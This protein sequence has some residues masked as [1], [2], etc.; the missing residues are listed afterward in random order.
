MGLMEVV[1]N[2]PRMRLSAPLLVQH[3]TAGDFSCRRPVQQAFACTLPRS[4]PRLD[5]QFQHAGATRDL[6]TFL[7]SC[8][9]VAASHR[10]TRLMAP[11]VV[12][13]PSP[14]SGKCSSA[15]LNSL[16]PQ[17]PPSWLILRLKSPQRSLLWSCTVH[18]P[19]PPPWLALERTDGVVPKGAE[20][21]RGRRKKAQ[22]SFHFHFPHQKEKEGE[23]LEEHCAR[24]VNATAQQ[25]TKLK[26]TFSPL[27]PFHPPPFSSL[28][29]PPF[30]P[31]SGCFPRKG[32]ALC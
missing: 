4:A 5:R 27:L 6:R 20:R 7:G 30:L 2:V 23:R 16:F 26:V 9:R 18:P 31:S 15:E 13:L 25:W 32:R 12:P 14:A 17:R 11:F 24:P 28:P 21:G 10:G 8:I 19:C 29:P 1:R 22:H 3:P